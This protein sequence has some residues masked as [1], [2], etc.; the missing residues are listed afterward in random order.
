M[1]VIVDKLH[2]MVNSH[3]GLA[4]GPQ[5]IIKGMN[6]IKLQ[7]LVGSGDFVSTCRLVSPACNL[8]YYP[9]RYIEYTL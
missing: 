1:L 7:A 6:R 2:S 4:I 8:T 5:L 3:S 9:K